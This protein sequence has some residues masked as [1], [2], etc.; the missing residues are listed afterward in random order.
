MSELLAYLPLLLG[1]AIIALG[2][3]II[4]KI[5]K[6]RYSKKARLYRI[7]NRGTAHRAVGRLE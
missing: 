4:K 6:P 1:L 3:A 5:Q 2:I 7:K